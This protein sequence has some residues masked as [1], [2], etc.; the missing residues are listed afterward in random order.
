MK[1]NEW[2]IVVALLALTALSVAFVSPEPREEQG[3]ATVV[4]QTLSPTAELSPTAQ[5]GAT[6]QPTPMPAATGVVVGA[7]PTP[8]TK[9]A[10]AVPTATAT[11]TATSTAT[12]TPFPFDTRPDLARFVYVD[13]RVQHLYV[14]E[15][16]QLLR[17]IP[18]STGLPN[19]DTYTEAWSG[20][21]GKYWGTFFSFGTY[22]DDAWYLYKSLGSILVHSLPYTEA[23]GYRTYQGRE[24]L[25]VKPSSHGCIRIAPEDARWFT[26]WNPEGVYMTI[27]DPYREMWR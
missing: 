9:T 13:Q 7:S 3:E 26:Q 18:C 22:Q 1:R 15:Q 4:T 16:G 17:D 20:A 8:R 6:G 12:P 25:G 27:T 14:F 11:P 19:D 2:L 5:P 24:F 23:D 10:T 21:I